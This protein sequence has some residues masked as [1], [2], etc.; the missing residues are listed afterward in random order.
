MGNVLMTCLLCARFWLDNETIATAKK[1]NKREWT[2]WEKEIT[3]GHQQKRI[4]T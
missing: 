3:K 1:L 2:S 4:K